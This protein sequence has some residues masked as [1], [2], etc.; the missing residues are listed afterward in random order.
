MTEVAPNRGFPFLTAT[1]ALL[2]LFLFVGLMVWQYGEPSPLGDPNADL[3]GEPKFE[4]AA[5]LDEL[6]AK[7]QAILDG[8]PGTGAKMSVSAATDDLLKKLKG[9]KDT[10]PFPT[11][12]PAVTE[13]KPK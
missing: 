7:N 13:P 3:K 1:A 2:A 9:P 8:K 6:R 4:P 10:L 11:P 5:H 12:E